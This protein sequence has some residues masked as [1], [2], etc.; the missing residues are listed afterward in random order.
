MNKKVL[1]GD[2]DSIYKL[3]TSFENIFDYVKYLVIIDTTIDENDYTLNYESY[4]NKFYLETDELIISTN[5]DYDVL[6]QKLPQVNR[7]IYAR[8]WILE[9]LKETKIIHKPKFIRLELST[10]CQLNCRECYMRKGNYGVV[11]KGYL[12]FEQF[13]QFIEENPF[14]QEIEVSNSGEVFLNPDLEKILKYSYEK[15]IYITME[16]GVN[17]NFVTESNLEALVKYHVKGITFSI[18]GVTQETYGYYRRNG[19]LNTVLNNI[20]KLNEYKRKY[21]SYYPKLKWQFII[22]NENDHEI[23]KAKELATSLNMDIFYKVD[24]S[25]KYIPKDKEKIKRITGI[26]FDDTKMTNDICKQMIFCPQINWDGR[27]LGCCVVY[28]DDWKVNVFSEGL[29]NA[30]NSKLYRKMIYTLLGDEPVNEITPCIDCETYMNCNSKG[31][32][33]II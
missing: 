31:M 5:Y 11:G 23:E 17:F 29:I 13:K 24:W 28:R 30:L 21:N 19:N 18:D 32:K 14:I 22:M 16:N 10:V 8:D 2:Y 25:G 4:L 7:I 20:R 3:I 1:I 33:I 6:K 27:L 15:N 26:N 12:K 9:M